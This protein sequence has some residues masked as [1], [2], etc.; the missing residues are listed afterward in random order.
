M[1]YVFKARERRPPARAD[2]ARATAA[3]DGGGAG[4]RPAFTASFTGFKVRAALTSS[5]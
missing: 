4:G 3:T 1:Q 2:T 5:G